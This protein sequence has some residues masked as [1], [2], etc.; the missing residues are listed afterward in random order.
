MRQSWL[1]IIIFLFSCGNE[2]QSLPP[3]SPLQSSSAEVLTQEFNEWLDERWE[4]EL[5]F[6]PMSRTSLGIKI[7]YDKLDDYTVEGEERELQWLRSS[8]A[9]MKENFNYEALTDDGKLSW[10]MWAHSLERVEQGIPFRGHQYL[11]GR[12]GIHSGLPNFL[13]NLH[14]VDSPE[15]LDAYLK[16]L[17]EI[18]RVFGEVLARALDNAEAGVRQP[19]FAYNFAIDE[20]QRVTAGIP[21][22][23]D[24]NTP[25]SPLWSDVQAKIDNL[26][27]LNLIDMGTA[28]LYRSEARR[29]L[30]GEVAKAYQ[31]VLTWLEEDKLN[32][33]DDARGVWALPDGEAYYNYRL[34]QMTT[35]SLSADEI[36]EIGLSEVDRLL[37]EMEVIKTRTGFDGSLSEFFDFV[38]QDPNN[39]YPGTEEGRQQYLSDNYA[40]L[41][42]INE[43]LPDYFGR[44]PKADLEIRRVEA[45]RE[46]DGAAQ[47]YRGA[48]PDGSRPGVYYSHMSDMS[49]LPKHQVEDVLYH[50]GNPGHHM[51][52]SIQQE[53]TDVPLFRTQY[54]T[55]AFVE[56]WGLYAEWLAKEMGGFEDPMSDFGRLGGEI[57]RAIRLVVDTGIHSKMWT[58]EQAVSYFL[59]NS[60]SSET[61]VRSE[62]QR[63]FTSPGQATAY[64]IGM[65][66]IQRARSNA[67]A[68]LGDDFDIRAFHDLVLGAGALPLPMLH[69]RVESWATNLREAN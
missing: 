52:I 68:I 41:N 12:G 55:T 50:E 23:S 27:E 51:Q 66:N 6:S 43:K 5:N 63:Y 38:R 7:D 4:E 69:A 44:L 65:I 36:H 10:D 2:N 1:I 31:E 45:F 39:Y 28:R 40:Y 3:S 20:I 58:E 13:I 61:T 59:E 47:H 46:Q 35:L 22:K 54:F 15:D 37:G 62:I 14:R 56:G 32:V 67:E 48:T 16:R 57:W 29:I 42:S 64:K 9:T 49:S 19:K 18:D 34:T 8:V 30:E 11:F 60:D 24:D 53:L 21:F 25:N 26:L 17:R 33:T